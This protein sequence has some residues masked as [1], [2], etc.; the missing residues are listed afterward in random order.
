ME[1]IHNRKASTVLTYICLVVFL[2]YSVFLMLKLYKVTVVDYDIHARD[3]AASQWK[4]MNYEA[5]RGLIYDANGIT[6]ASNTYNYTIVCTPREIHGDNLNRTQIINNFSVLLDLSVEELDAIIPP[7]II[8]ED[9]KEEYDTTDPRYAVNGMDLKRNITSEQKDQFEKFVMDN[10]ISG[11]SYVAIPQRYYNYGRFASQIIGYARNNGDGLNGLYGLEAYYNSILSGTNGHRYSEV[12]LSTG[13]ALP[14]SQ[15]ITTAVA[16]GY[17]LVLN[18]DMNIQMIAEE[19]CRAAYETYSPRGGI[20]CI[21]MNPNTGAVYAMVSLP[22]Y[23]LNDPYGL[24]YGMNQTLWNTWDDE[25]QVNYL[26][27]SVWRNRCIS[28]TYEPGSTFKS[29]TTAMAFEENLTNE[30][31]EFSDAPI[32]VSDLDTISCWMQK[33]YGYNH[34]VET[35]TQGFEQSCNPIFVHLAELITVPRY[36]KYV[37]ALGFY[38]PTGID[39]PAEGVGIFHKNPTY[40]DMA[41]LSFGESATVTPIQ[42]L[43]SYCALI[44]GGSLMTPHIVKYITDQDGNIVNEIEPEI[45]RTVFSE[46]TC[47]RV[48]GLMEKV[49]EEGTGSAGKVLGYSV[50]GKTSTATI[51]TGEE[52]GMHVLSFSCYAPSYSPEIAV[53]VVLNRPEDK[54]VG[55]S[56]PAAVSARI[57]ERTL[58]YMNV[59][60]IFTEADYERLVEYRYVLNVIGYTASKASSNLASNGVTT[61]Y[62]A[63]NMNSESIVGFTYPSST[64]YLYT[65]G[66]AIVVLYPEGAT[67]DDMLITSVPSL[68]GKNAVE[69]FN[70]LSNCNLNIRYEGDISGVC[71][72]QSYNYLETI[73]AGSIVTVTMGSPADI[74]PV[75]EDVTEEGGELQ[76]NEMEGEVLDGEEISSDEIVEE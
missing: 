5:E 25:T 70:S 63:E 35:L 29:L 43:N 67:T 76:D 10:N 45:I 9:G 47:R 8:N 17:N 24:P 74:T 60:R 62:G 20:T 52:T 40:I 6:L 68:T 58:T 38:E 41:C 14:Y 55:S 59:P 36:Y 39:L 15:P 50:A 26:M 31:V 56:A 37:H 71:I 46:E 27:S 49:V 32:Q 7:T 61:I 2:L 33:S 73:P 13:G 69:C 18:I 66:S 48:R 16:N 12:D 65:S 30:N 22:D 57:V 51:E 75:P 3:A 23:D 28:D 53:L 72:A 1:R 64:D 4:L 44:N 34:G 54:S 19:E 21:V 42:L 11:V